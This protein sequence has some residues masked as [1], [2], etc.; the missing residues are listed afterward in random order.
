MNQTIHQTIQRSL[1][2]LTLLFTT[3]SQAGTLKEDFIA[4]LTTMKSVYDAEYAP[5]AWKKNFAGFDLQAEYNKAVSMVQSSSHFNMQQGKEILKNFIYS[6]KDYHTSISFVS[7]EKA[8]L[9]FTIQSARKGAGDRF[10]IVFINREKLPESDFPF[11]TG[12]E[13]VFFDG[14]PTAQ[15]VAEVQSETPGNVAG[16]DQGLAELMLTARNG[17]RGIRIPQGVV[18]LGIKR[19]GSEQ[20][21]SHQLVWEYIPELIHA[22]N[23]FALSSLESFF[24]NWTSPLSLKKNEE[25]RMIKKF[26]MAADVSMLDIAPENPY[27]LGAR[28]TFTPDLGPKVWESATNDIFYAYIYKRA[29]RK[30]IGYVRIPQYVVPDYNKAIDEFT[31]IVARFELNTDA[32]VIDQV[33]NPG[34]SVFYLYALAAT[35]AKDPLATPRHR[36]AVNQ[37]DVMEALGQIEMLSKIKND[38]EAKKLIPTGD[39][40]GY[41][42][43]YEFVQFTI[44]YLKFLVS[45]WNAGR[46]LTQPYWIAGVDHINPAKTH[47]SKPVLLLVNQLDFSG[48]DFFPAILQDNKRVTILGSRTSGAGGYVYDVRIQNNIGIDRFRCTESIAE[49]ADTH[50]IENLGVK[51]D[52]EYV[53]SDKDFTENYVDYLKA[54]DTAIQ[55]LTG[56]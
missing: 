46:K 45:E 44:N 15:A 26:T 7:T 49:R 9:P 36:M 55:Q 52:I 14:K 35:L 38:E 32:M 56:N 10:Y 29:D 6:M 3:S 4:N 2:I 34:G 20:V 22:R 16:T 19:K 23:D 53:M 50:P 48:G 37:A 24:P 12:D 40:D 28:K 8:S 33:N 11:Q 31:K 41:P 54:I 18:T 25:P 21:V 5:A 42:A 1:L 47:Y 51:P 17:S 27:G 30:L 39:L 13:L 43:S